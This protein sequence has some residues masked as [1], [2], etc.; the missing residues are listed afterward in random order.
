M[1]VQSL[2]SLAQWLKDPVL[3]Q[4]VVYVTDV[5][6][7]LHCCLYELPCAIG[8]VQKS[9]KKKKIMLSNPYPN[10]PYCNLYV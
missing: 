5:A 6:Q 2:A 4:G 10:L 7:I 1:Q 8:T 9:K 3:L